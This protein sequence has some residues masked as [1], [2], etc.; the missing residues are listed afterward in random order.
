MEIWVE[1]LRVCINEINGAFESPTP[2]IAINHFGTF[3][4]PDP[5]CELVKDYVVKKGAFE[6]GNQKLFGALKQRLTLK[7]SQ[8]NRIVN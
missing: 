8:H 4:L 6:E 7:K 5:F 3:N 1:K 2:R